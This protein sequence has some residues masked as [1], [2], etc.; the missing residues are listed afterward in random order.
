MVITVFKPDGSTHPFAVVQYRFDGEP[1]A[2]ENRP[3]GNSKN[4]P[5]FV[6]TKKSTL[7]KLSAALKEHGSIKQAVHIIEDD[8]GLMAAS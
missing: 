6:P 2:V 5:P 1:H 3:H 8:G 4:G 7:E